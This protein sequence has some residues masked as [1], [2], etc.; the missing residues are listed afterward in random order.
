V[1]LA[2]AHIHL[3][4]EGYRRVGL[5]SLFGGGEL[6]AYEALRAAHGV[7]LALAIGYEAEGIDQSNNSYIAGLARSR[8]WLRTLA[9]LETAPAPDAGAIESSLAAGHSGLAIY[10]ID[11]ARAEA[12]FAWPRECWAILQSRRALV[13]FNA[14]P[15]ATAALDRLTGEWPGV[16]F[17][18]SHLGLPGV[19]EAGAGAAATK[20]RLAPLLAQAGRPNVHVKISGLYATS[21]PRH[22]FPHDGAREAVERILDGFGPERCLWA[23]DFA[24]A[25]EFVSFAQTIDWPGGAALSQAERRLVMHDNLARLLAD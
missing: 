10:A 13:S 18:F 19:L 21:E 1:R 17:L 11:R 16:Q 4:R 14:R 22:A 8:S 6:R 2:D 24:P 5:P 7:D 15:E 23:S 25:L 3:F 12:T 20:E 9:Y